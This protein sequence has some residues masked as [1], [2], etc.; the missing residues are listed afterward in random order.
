[1]IQPRLTPLIEKHYRD[2]KFDLALKHRA[3]NQFIGKDGLVPA[4]ECA[5]LFESGPEGRSAR[6][7][8]LWFAE[9]ADAN[10]LLMQHSVQEFDVVSELGEM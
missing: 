3:T 8:Y 7:L 1:M 4:W 6:E 2:L 5:L 10:W 9:D